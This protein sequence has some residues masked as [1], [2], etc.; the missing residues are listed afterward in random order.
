MARRPPSPKV[1]AHVVLKHGE[2]AR[3]GRK[4]SQDAAAT[5]LSAKELKSLYS[6]VLTLQPPDKFYFPDGEGGLR[7]ERVPADFPDPL[8]EAMAKAFAHFKLDPEDPGSWRALV[9]YFSYIFFW[10]PPARRSGAKTKWTSDRER[11]LYQAVST[12]PGLSDV[13]AAMKLANDKRSPFYVRGTSPSDGVRGL[14]SRIGK[15]RKK[16]AGTK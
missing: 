7:E 14:R 4:L 5:G 12:L 15:V 10:Q 2:K 8:R 1:K 16:F 6:G 9:S 3:P 11:E 13:Q